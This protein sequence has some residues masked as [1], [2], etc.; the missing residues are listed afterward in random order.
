MLK[1]EVAMQFTLIDQM[2]KTQT[3]LEKVIEKIIEGKNI[4]LIL[5][6]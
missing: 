4:P 1:N 6:P 3:T 2:V 5:S